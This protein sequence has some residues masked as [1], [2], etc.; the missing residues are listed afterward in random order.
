MTNRDFITLLVSKGYLTKTE[1]AI[2]NEISYQGLLDTLVGRRS[3]RKVVDALNE[4][5][6][7]ESDLPI[8]DE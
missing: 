1:F 7:S 5:G 4:I 8:S 3:S 6:V 2:K